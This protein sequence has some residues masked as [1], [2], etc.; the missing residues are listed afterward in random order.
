MTFF[1]I[2]EPVISHFTSSANSSYFSLNS[3]VKN[4]IE[5]LDKIDQTQISY[6]ISFIQ[7]KFN[8]KMNE[9]LKNEDTTLILKLIYILKYST[10]EEITSQIEIL[11]EFYL[12]S[13]YLEGLILSGNSKSSI[14][15]LENYLNKTD[16]LLVS[17]ILSNFFVD[18]KDIFYTK[19]ESELFES[20]NKLMMFNERIHLTQKL[21]EITAHMSRPPMMSPSSPNQEK[22]IN[23]TANNFVELVLNCFYCN[24][25]IYKDK[26]EQFR[27][28]FLNN[29]ESSEYV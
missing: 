17:Y 27:N 18:S 8:T 12:N 13:G 25:K 21:N 28:L 10:A 15:L 2:F 5:T 9:F 26:M 22:K 14:K 20:L 1:I 11:E 23:F 4:L 7:Q 24:A 19:C 29:K 6:L 3:T 16:D